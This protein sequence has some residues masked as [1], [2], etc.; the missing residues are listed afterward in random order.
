MKKQLIFYHGLIFCALLSVLP[1]IGQQ[2]RS[3][4]KNDSNT[5]L[6]LLQP[7]YKTPY[8]I[9]EKNVVKTDLDRILTYLEGVTP[10]VLENKSTGKEVLSNVDFNFETQIKRGDFRLGSYEWGV[11]YA[12]MLATAEITGDKRYE[13]Y[14]NQRF[15]FLAENYPY[16]RK[17]YTDYGSNIDSQI[18]QIVNPKALDDAGAVCAAM[19]KATRRNPDLKLRPLIDNYMNFIMYQEYRLYDGTF[20]RKRPQLNTIWLDDMYMSIPAL[21]QMGKLTG[22]N[23]YSDEAVKQINSFSEKMFVAEKG[24]F[25]HGWV[26]SM[27]EHPSF[28]WARA[29]GWALLALT[30]A[31]DALPESH[32]QKDKVL[33]LFKSHISGLLPLQSGDGFWHQLLDRNDSYPETSATAIYVYCIAHA[34][35]KG[36]LDAT[37]YGSAALLGWN[38]VSTK[39]NA[40]GQVE[41]TC[42]GTGMAFDPAFYC[43]R[44]VSPYAAHGYG[45]VIMAGAEIINLLEKQHPKMNDNTIQFYSNDQTTSTPIFSINDQSRPDEIVSGSTRK[46][47]DAPVVFVIGDSTAKN[48]RGKG[49]GGQWGWGSF[50]Q[51]FLDTTRIS[52]ENH[53]L[54]GRSSRTFYTEGLWDK[55][56]PG[57][58]KGDIVFI[59]FGH[60]DGGPLNTGRARA[61]LK[62][63]GENSETVIM[64]RTGG[65]EEV[66]TFG[67]YLRIYIRQAKAIGA[68]PVVLS[69]TPGNSWEGGKMLRN[70]DTY[71][72]WSKEVAEQEGVYFID[73][74]DIVARKCESLGQE[75]TNEL[76]KDRVHTSYEGAM[77]NCKSLI[78]GIQNV[79]ELTLNKYIK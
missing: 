37:A 21:V 79:P 66:F 35:N 43:Y 26:E 42:V 50:F 68:V 69:H 47:K 8:R 36:W 65:P 2:K 29:N 55:V 52:V 3:A 31:L 44:P 38:A 62:G 49:D 54:G 63:T 72:G 5:P 74:N 24:L 70:S 48:G 39:I 15:S 18:R 60:N 22:E 17:L 19:I 27:K 58:K 40:Q 10:A 56:L 13:N 9:P 76:Y 33:E 16:F 41:G 6:H 64:E 73:M 71:G 25:R 57:I 46:N 20:A 32:P 30:E 11:T 53:A 61:S 12:A 75:K 7:D 28:F 67:H 45:T 14:V 1:A 34:I 78:E 23:K 4:V 51:Q 77:L 59:Q